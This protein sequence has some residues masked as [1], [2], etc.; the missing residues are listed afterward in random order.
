MRARMERKQSVHVVYRTRILTACI[1]GHGTS[2]PCGWVTW[3]PRWHPLT[4][5]R[6]QFHSGVNISANL[7]RKEWTTEWRQTSFCLYTVHKHRQGIIQCP[8]RLPGYGTIPK[9]EGAR[10]LYNCWTP[11][12]KNVTTL[13][14]IKFYTLEPILIILGIIYAETTGF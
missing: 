13:I 7:F 8:N 4:T 3:Y 10:P 5:W 11:C 2:L 1:T 14:V 6:C 12:L 9:F